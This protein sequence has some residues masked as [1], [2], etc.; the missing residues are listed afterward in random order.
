MRERADAIGASFS[1][2]SASGRGT[3]IEVKVPLQPQRSLAVVGS[4][5]A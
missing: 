2:K 5:R 3:V 4:P 1:I